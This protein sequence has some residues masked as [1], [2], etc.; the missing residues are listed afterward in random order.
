MK[1]HPSEMHWMQR[2]HLPQVRAI[3]LHP[4]HWLGEHQL[5]LAL[6][7]TGLITLF[8][9]GLALLMNNSIRIDLPYKGINY[10]TMYPHGGGAF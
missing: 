8:I 5:L 10:P 6:I 2:M 7:I 4:L 9:V 1:W 3:H